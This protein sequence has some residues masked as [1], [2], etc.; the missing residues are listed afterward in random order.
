[1][2]N[3]GLL[4]SIK[5]DWET[6]QTDFNTWNSSY[7]FTLDPCCTLDN[8]KCPD[9]M[10]YDLGQDGLT[11]PWTGR[12]FMN[13]PYLDAKLWVPKAHA[14]AQRAAVE[15]V[16]GLLPARTDTVLFHKYIWDRDNC[17]CRPGAA[18]DFLPGRL[19]F[20]SDQYW[21]SIWNSEF[22]LD[23]KGN[24]KENPLYMEYGKKQPSPFPSML[25]CW[26]SKP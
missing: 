24:I 2:L 18:V 15:F 23:A 17:Q 13:P 5:Q 26:T 16:V 4:S 10:Y 8:C 14:E 11:E 9:G 22:I 6:P 21:E 1:M 3:E 19:K 25:V 20:G 7:D 12:V